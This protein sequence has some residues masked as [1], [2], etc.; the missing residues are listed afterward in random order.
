MEAQQ[1][2]V[3]TRQQFAATL[4]LDNDYAAVLLS[5]MVRDKVLIRVMRGKYSLP[6]TDILCIA[7]AL[8]P[9]SYVSLWKAFEYYGTTTQMP[10]ITDVICTK[11]PRII[12]VTLETGNFRIRFIKTHPSNISGI[13]KARIDGKIAFIAEKERAVVDGLQYIN[14]VPLSEVYC[15]LSSGAE[16]EKIIDFAKRTGIQA[17]MKRAGYLLEKA[18]FACTPEDF[19]KLSKTYVPLDPES[20]KRGKHDRK[21]RIIA[22]TVI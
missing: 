3:F 18:G 22:N 10:T 1:L 12:S 2:P 13:K 4:G 21:W 14:Y 5:R 9:P 19:G 6:D 7:S 20:P 15:A 8:H 17:V 11:R 16:P